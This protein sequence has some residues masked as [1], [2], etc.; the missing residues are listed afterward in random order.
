MPTYS[1]AVNALENGVQTIN[2]GVWTGSSLTQHYVLVGGASSAITSI[3]P[4]TSTYVLT[5]NG[6]GSDPSF[7]AVSASGAVISLKADDATTATP[8]SGV[9]T[10]SGGSTGLTTTASSHTLSFLGTLAI[11]YGGTGVAS[12]TTSPT[13][14][15]WAGWDANKNFSA[16]SLISAYA[17]TATAA[18]LTTLDVTSKQQQYFTGSTTQ[19]VKMPVTST[20]VLGQQYEIV[21]NSSGVV[22]VESSGSN[23]IIAMPAASVAYLTCINTGVTT[24]AGWNVIA[25]YEANGIVN[26]IADNSGIATGESVTISGGSTGLTTTASSSTV[27][28]TG[29]LVGANGGTGVANTSRTITLSSGATGKVLTSDSSGNGTWATNPVPGYAFSAYLTNSISN[30]TGNGTVYTIVY[31]T[32]LVNASSVYSTST[33]LFTAPVNGIY[34]FNYQILVATTSGSPYYSTMNALI[35]INGTQ[36]YKNP[37]VYGWP[38]SYDINMGSVTIPLSSGD[39]VGI[40]IGGNS[41][42]G[43]LDVSVVGGPVNRENNFSGFLVYPT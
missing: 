14:S 18:A 1:N 7:Q 24:A 36:L 41:Q 34:Q 37:T 26:L 2:S 12:V 35:I 16:N 3:S 22:T 40:G 17:T 8:S 13:A 31:D 4:S 5:S 27:D 39:T 6:T 42:S 33:G 21:N 20:L 15:A 9:I 29:V 23:T 38:N 32:T 43:T 30:V 25:E 19:T 28:L 11:G 10:V